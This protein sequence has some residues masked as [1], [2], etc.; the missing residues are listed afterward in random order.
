MIL[1]HFKFAICRIHGFA[2]FVGQV[3]R[4]QWL[5]A[6]PAEDGAAARHIRQVTHVAHNI[7][8]DTT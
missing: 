1:L 5:Q 2:L 7:G 3:A 4:E 6:G 8:Y